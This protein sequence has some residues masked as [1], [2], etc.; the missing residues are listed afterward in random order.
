[1]ECEICGS[2]PARRRAEIEG[3]E[4][5]VC[6]E[7]V[8]LGTEIKE[9]KVTQKGRKEVPEIEES[10]TPEYPS[11][12]RIARES[13]G[14]TREELARRIHEKES[15]I[16][17][18]ESGSMMP[19]LSLARKLEKELRIILVLKEEKS[20]VHIPEKPKP[21]ITIGDVVEVR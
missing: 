2:S 3:V 17:R 6:D 11:R 8:S 20:E 7:C 15:V 9:P 19:P 10:I 1:M 13:L 21:R 12:I 4:L 14:L 18:L 5:I 16:S